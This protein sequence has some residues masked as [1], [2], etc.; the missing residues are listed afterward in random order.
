MLPV[1]KF[2]SLQ[3]PLLVNISVIFNIKNALV[4]VS[5]FPVLPLASLSIMNWPEH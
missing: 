3:E 1:W 4:S 5:S 2:R